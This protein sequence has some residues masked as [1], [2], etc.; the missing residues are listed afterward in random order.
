MHRSEYD[1]NWPNHYEKERLRLATTLGMLLDGGLI[2]SIAHVGATSVSDLAGRPCIDIALTALPFP[3]EEARRTQ[4]NELGY[5]PVGADDSQTE[6]RF[7]HQN[8]GFQLWICQAGMT[9]WYDHVL[10]RDYLRSSEEARFAYDAAR[11]NAK[12]LDA[13]KEEILPKM[14]ADAHQ[15][16]I[17]TVDFAPVKAVQEELAGFDHPWYI[18]SGW[19]VDLYLGEVTRHHHDVDVVVPR[20]AQLALQSFLTERGWRWLTP[21]KG[22]LEPWPPHMRIELPRHQVHAHRVHTHRDSEFMD[23]LLTDFRAGC[24][25]FRR[26]PR[27]LRSMEQ[28]SLT[29]EGGIHYLAPELVLLFKAKSAKNNERPKD[30]DDFEKLYP[31]LDTERRA[32][33]RWALIASDVKHPWI[34]LL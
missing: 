7:L 12:E 30:Q 20:D 22:M 34:E 5:H 6:A 14:L 19:A 1:P 23:C 27:I 10:L 11:Q 17:E 8:G 15:W 13:V 31:Q 4:L 26:D 25:S 33:L 24:W 3:L 21:L 29:T 28:A 2:E 16:W 32:W 9:P 18:S